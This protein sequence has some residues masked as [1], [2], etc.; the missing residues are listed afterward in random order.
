VPVPYHATR[1]TGSR[2]S[3]VLAVALVACVTAAMWPRV[4][5]VHAYATYSVAGLLSA[6]Q[7]R[8]GSLRGRLIAVHGYYHHGCPSCS[9]D[10]PP[11]LTTSPSWGGPSI[12][13]ALPDTTASAGDPAWLSAWRAL[14]LL[15]RLAPADPGSPPEG[16][17]TFAGT[18]GPLCAQTTICDAPP[19]V[20]HVRG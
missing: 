18:I 20:L 11:S 16:F 10:A 15:G 19:F 2:W 12:I 17:T 13:V 3:I 5:T 14:P 1:M 6:V 8:Q 4:R 9:W 7:T